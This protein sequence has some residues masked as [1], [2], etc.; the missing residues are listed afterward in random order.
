MQQTKKIA[1]AHHKAQE[2]QVMKVD[3][4]SVKEETAQQSDK[5]LVGTK[6]GLVGDKGK[7]HGGD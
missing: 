6:E 2:E 4:A 5:G 3:R 7:D 1:N